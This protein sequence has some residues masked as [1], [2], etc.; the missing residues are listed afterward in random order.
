MSNFI[1][2]KCKKH[3]IHVGNYDCEFGK[4]STTNHRITI[5]ST[6]QR[7]SIP[8]EH[9]SKL[10]DPRKN[11]LQHHMTE[12][13][14]YENRIRENLVMSN[15]ES[16]GDNDPDPKM[17]VVISSFEGI[18]ERMEEVKRTFEKEV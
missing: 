11:D 12:T 7:V 5:D 16:D 14:V 9:N 6:N 2:G 13:K 10:K 4:D 3:S 17:E 18:D 15:I 8:W 1:T